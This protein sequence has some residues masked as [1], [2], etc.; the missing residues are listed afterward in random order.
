M[1]IMARG[2]SERYRFEWTAP[3]NARGSHSAQMISR[4]RRQP[5][6]DRFTPSTRKET[7]SS[8]M[9]QGALRMLA[10]GY[11][12]KAEA[13]LSIPQELYYSEGS[14]AR[15]YSK[16]ERHSLPEFLAGFSTG[17]L[18]HPKTPYAIVL[19]ETTN[20]VNFVLIDINQIGRAHV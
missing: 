6:E 12:A 11:D 2:G 1:H 7:R 14:C 19:F 3:R 17:K 8:E 5:L 18:I 20:H 13:V 10:R 15:F 4:F 9:L 16:A